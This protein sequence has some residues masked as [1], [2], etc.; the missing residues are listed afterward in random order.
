MLRSGQRRG[1]RPQHTEKSPAARES[2]ISRH[3]L[4][5][6]CGLESSPNVRSLLRAPGEGR[7]NQGDEGGRARRLNVL[8]R[9]AD[10]HS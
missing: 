2:Q 5:R 10:T 1:G 6:S 4:K 3:L 8:S 7:E 9:Q